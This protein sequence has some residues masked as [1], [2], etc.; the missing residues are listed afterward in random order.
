MTDVGSTIARDAGRSLRAITFD[1]GTPLPFGVR[2][3]C[4]GFNFSVFSRHAETMELLLFDARDAIDPAI[5]FPLDPEAHR[6]GDVWHVLVS[7]IG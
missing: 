5:V 7:G 3:C 2:D 1:I 6:T 4:A